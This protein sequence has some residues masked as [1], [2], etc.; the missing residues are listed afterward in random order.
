LRDEL[1]E[2]IERRRDEMN[3]ILDDYGVPRVAETVR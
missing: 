2:L 3:K 1:D